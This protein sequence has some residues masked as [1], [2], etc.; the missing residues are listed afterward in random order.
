MAKKALTA[1]YG[2]MPFD[3]DDMTYQ[4]L[5]DSV[6]IDNNT[7]KINPKK[8]PLNSD[9]ASFNYY[10]DA[11]YLG[12]Y[13]FEYQP[14]KGDTVYSKEY[15]LAS[16]PVNG[17]TLYS[18]EYGLA[19]QPAS[20]A[21]E[22]NG[23]SY[24]LIGDAVA[25]GTDTIAWVKSF[26]HLFDEGNNT[27]AKGYVRAQAA[28]DDSDHAF[29]EA[30]TDVTVVGAD[31]TLIWNK[32]E[33]ARI[34]D[35]S[36]DL[37]ITEFYAIDVPWW[38]GDT[39]VVFSDDNHIEID[40]R[41]GPRAKRLLEKKFGDIFDLDGNLAIV[42]VEATAEGDNS[43]VDVAANVLAL[44]DELSEATASVTAGGSDIV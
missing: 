21:V 19:S 8:L 18:R 29:A 32:E 28:A 20:T 3:D 34:N 39:T 15:G 17:D 16:Q 1:G 22:D 44:E 33:S 11:V 9:D 6:A 25:V 5:D 37:S 12:E 30:V 24:E 4:S 42:D 40:G 23:M 35:I 41:L 7:F 14:A 38:N 10:G 31:L 27:I 13:Q 26:S 43:F 2:K 36:V